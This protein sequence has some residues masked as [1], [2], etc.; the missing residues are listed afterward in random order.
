MNYFLMVL[1]ALAAASAEVPSPALPHACDL[2]RTTH[3]PQP[4]RE[5]K[6]TGPTPESLWTSE[7]GLRL[8]QDAFPPHQAWAPLFGLARWPLPL[9]QR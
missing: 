1:Q 4:H 5:T 3:L 6:K 8:R 7:E 2:L 9:S